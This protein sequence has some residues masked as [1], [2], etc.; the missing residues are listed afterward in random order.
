[1]NSHSDTPTPTPAKDSS[2][3]APSCCSEETSEAK[4]ATATT[5]DPTTMS[6]NELRNTVREKYG[7][8]ASAAKF[9]WKARF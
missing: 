3:C 5:A 2:C 8:I 1:M 7:A 4:A 9:R 6:A